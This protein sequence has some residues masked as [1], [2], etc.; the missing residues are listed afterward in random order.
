MILEHEKNVGKVLVDGYGHKD[1][2][3]KKRKYVKII[4]RIKPMMKIL[5]LSYFEIV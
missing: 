2:F 3:G 1:H 4:Y 5:K